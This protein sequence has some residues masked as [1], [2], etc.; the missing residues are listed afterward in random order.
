MDRPL[1]WTV[2]DETGTLYVQYNQVARGIDSIANEILARA[3]QPGIKHVVVDM[4]HNGGGDNTTYRRLLGVLQD[5]AINQPGRLTLLIGRLTFSAAA[6]FAT[7]VERTTHAEFA[8]EAMGGSPNLYGDTR[9]TTLPFSGQTALIAT[10]YWEKSTADDNRLTIR[11]DLRIV[12]TS[13]DYFSGLDPVLLGV[14]GGTP[15]GRA[16]DG[17]GAG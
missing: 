4:R 6:N 10:I 5:P 11:P 1:W 3:K 9:P 15:V 14:I 13:E 12:L 17:I 16:D 8:G 2:L 7:E